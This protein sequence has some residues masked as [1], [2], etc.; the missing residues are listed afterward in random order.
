MTSRLSHR[1]D[2]RAQRRLIDRL[3]HDHALLKAVAERTQDRVMMSGFDDPIVDQ[4]GL[5]ALVFAA[6]ADE[7]T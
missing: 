4:L 3:R 5:V 7:L 6:L 2:R 1:P